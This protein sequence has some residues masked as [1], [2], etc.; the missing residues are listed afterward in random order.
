MGGA[1]ARPRR[2]RRY[3]GVVARTAHLTEDF[4][5]AYARISSEPWIAAAMAR[6]GALEPWIRRQQLAIAAIPAPT[7]GEGLR[8]E[9]MAEQLRQLRLAVEIDAAGNVLA[10][11]AAP[12]AGGAE[13]RI[14]LSAHLDTAF[15]PGTAMTARLEGGVLRGPSVLDNAAGLAGMLAL[16]RVCAEAG[17]AAHN[18]PFLFAGTVG[19]EGEGNLRGMR[20]LF[21]GP[22]APRIAAA[23]VLD[24]PG[25]DITTRALGSRRFQVHVTAPGGHSWANAGMPSAI[26]ALVRIAA[27]LLATAE[28]APGVAACSIGQIAGGGAIN[29]LAAAA[30]MKVDLRAADPERLEGL[31]QALT[32]AVAAGTAVENRAAAGGAAEARLE[33]L[34]D[35][36]AATL[37][38][39]S[40]LRAALAQVDRALGIE[41][42]DTLASTDANL[43]LSLGRSALRVGAG[44]RGGGGHTL[45]EWYDPSGRALALGRVLLLMALLAD[46]GL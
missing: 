29:A 35:R 5:A 45:Q 23:L 37:P 20:H 40:G 19:E 10:D 27:R 32:A 3:P 41:A 39:E 4:P 38:P 44:G 42:A 17:P 24:G 22:W 46:A 1:A 21:S 33:P 34:G 2:A 26:H 18:W 16:A 43:P 7:G 12:R 15:P 14:L 30:S 28:C 9:W 13:P 31:T 6:L 36:P 25:L 11:L 8:A